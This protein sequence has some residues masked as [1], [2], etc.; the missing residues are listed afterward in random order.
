M[1]VPMTFYLKCNDC[2]SYFKKTRGDCISIHNLELRCPY[3]RS[4]K[5]EKVKES[6]FKEILSYMKYKVMK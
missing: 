3:C 2:K 6:S 1:C 5:L 4:T